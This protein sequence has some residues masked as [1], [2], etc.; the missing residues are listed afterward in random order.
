MLVIGAGGLAKQ[1][2]EL[3]EDSC[4]EDHLN[5]FDDTHSA[6]DSFLDKYPV[7]HS[8]KNIEQHF[9]DHGNK[10]IVAVS[11]PANRKMFYDK[12]IEMGGEPVSLLSSNARYGRYQQVIG[13]GSTVLPG[14]QLESSTTIGRGALLNL[15]VCVTHDSSVGDF[16]E[17]GPGVIICG[18]VKIGESCFFGAGSIVL[19]GITISDNSVIGAGAVVNKDT[20]AG[21]KILGIPGRSV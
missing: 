20:K 17:F 8:F 6:P 10:F 21:E 16:C 3:I 13:A 18:R 5:F 2:I 14:C 4:G 11:G 12:L 7:I 15:N 19:P 1:M 9:L